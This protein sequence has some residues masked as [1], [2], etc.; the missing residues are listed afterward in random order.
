M[1]GYE[2]RNEGAAGGD[3]CINLEWKG[4]Q[5][6]PCH[7]DAEWVTPDGRRLCH[8]HALFVCGNRPNLSTKT[9]DG[10]EVPVGLLTLE[11]YY[12]QKQKYKK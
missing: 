9:V 7:K 11:Q 8:E 5:M 12:E 6:G 1:S 4:E 10:K 3:L 2:E